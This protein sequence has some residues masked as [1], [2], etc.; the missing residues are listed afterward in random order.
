MLLPCRWATANRVSSIPAGDKDVFTKK[1]IAR[2][3]PAPTLRVSWTA[4]LLLWMAPLAWGQQPD[5]TDQSHPLST[6][7]NGS[8]TQTRAL[9]QT[10]EQLKRAQQQQQQ[11]IE[12][13]ERENEQHELAELKM[14]AEAEASTGGE[15]V[16][17]ADAEVDLAEKIYRGGQR[18]LQALNP[19]LSVVGD[20]FGKIIA[21]KDGYRG[22]DDRSGF[23]FRM[24]G[25][26]F[27]AS[28]DPFAFTKVC[29]P[30]TSQGVSLGEAYLTW[31]S[32]LPGLS[33]TVG[34]FRQQFGVVNRWHV[35]SL[36]QVEFPLAMRTILG[37]AG[38]NQVGLS[39]DW[40]LSKL[41]AHAN[42]IILQLTNG[43]NEQLFSGSFFNIPAVLLRL[44]SYYDLTET[45]YFELG[46]TGMLG[47]NHK[48]G[49]MNETSGELEDE[50]HRRTWVAGADWTLLWEPLRQAR[51]WNFVFRG[52]LYAADKAVEGSNIRSLGMYQYA[53]AKLFQVWEVGTRFDWTMPFELDND[54]Q[55][56]FGVQ[57]YVTWWQSPWVKARL[58]YAWTRTA[59]AQ[60]AE[61]DHR[62]FLQVTFAAGPHKHERY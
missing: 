3:A 33:L 10:V 25:I 31:T 48:T 55:S 20:F 51:Y 45:T 24:V 49:V 37:P 53:Q 9:L 13:L 41:W 61:D 44:K 43:Q 27:Q 26:H 57:P 56:I 16:R 36:D 28:L 18:A 29:I 5:A 32:L 39:I 15:V 1:S 30:I 46:L 7:R 22:Q 42:S 23:F 54:G 21:N 59:V 19:E 35:P 8:A 50:Q 34:K 47:W 58:L 38:L 12:A 17:Q 4:L 2:V 14:A 6:P 62:V 52:E 60:P 40:L 11:R